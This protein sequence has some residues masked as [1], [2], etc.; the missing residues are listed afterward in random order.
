MILPPEMLIHIV[1]FLKGDIP[2]NIDKLF[3]NIILESKCKL[4]T[5]QLLTASRI[6]KFETSLFLKRIPNSFIAKYP[7]LFDEILNLF[8]EEKISVEEMKEIIDGSFDYDLWDLAKKKL[9][10]LLE[11]EIEDIPSYSFDVIEK[12]LNQNYFLKILG[13]LKSFEA[14]EREN[15]DERDIEPIIAALLG[16]DQLET[17]KLFISKIDKQ[18]ENICLFILTAIYFKNQTTTEF[19]IKSFYKIRKQYSILIYLFLSFCGNFRQLQSFFENSNELKLLVNAD[20]LNSGALF[21]AAEKGNLEAVRYLMESKYAIPRC[22]ANADNSYA[23]RL[24]AC[25]GHLELVRYLMESEYA[26]PRCQANADDSRALI[27]AARYGHLEIV[28]YLM[29]SEYAIPRCEANADGSDGLISAAEYGHLNVVQ[30]LM[31]SKY[32][33]P[34]CRANADNSYGLRW[35]AENGH[36]EVVRYLM[37][38][39]FAVPRCQANA[40]DS[41]ALIWAA[42]Y[43]H[44]EVVKYLMESEYAVPRCKANADDSCTLRLAA[45]NGHLEV[46]KYLVENKYA[47]PR[48]D[49]DFI[50]KNESGYSK[51]VIDYFKDFQSIKP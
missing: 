40:D 18:K 14:L 45:Q 27:W 41:R 33:I 37:E 30:Y 47:V 23:L 32:A 39:K 2:L 3:L 12:A 49:F 38:S 13:K 6:V 29:E 48:C 4:T 28:K 36:L 15:L 9:K 10:E 34:R 17:A 25:D 50:L 16:I 5:K 44:L 26:V 24:A 42:E 20:V 21:L 31:E 22:Q 35:A 51:K 19:F 1:S 43:G 46:V 8:Y 7:I 11:N